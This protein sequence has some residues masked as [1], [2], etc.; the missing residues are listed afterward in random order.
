MKNRGKEKS[1]KMK[2]LSRTIVS[3]QRQV[4]QE[5]EDKNKRF[6]LQEEGRSPAESHLSGLFSIFI[7]TEKVGVCEKTEF[8]DGTKFFKVIGTKADY[9][10]GR[11]DITM[12][13][14]CNETADEMQSR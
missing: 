2:N 5:W 14:N 6:L 1:W 8:T 11:K 13:S 10:E 12:L 9:D 3:R 7:S 4:S